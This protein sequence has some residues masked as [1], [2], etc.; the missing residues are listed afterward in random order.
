MIQM[1]EIPLN[2]ETLNILSELE[3][4]VKPEH[5]KCVPVQGR[6]FKGKKQ[7]YIN[8]DY[9]R[10]IRAKGR[11]H[12]GFPEASLSHSFDPAVLET[13]DQATRLSYLMKG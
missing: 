6:E 4:F 3:W 2:E 8:H 1:D 7:K 10:E 12:N 13:V 5:Y 9:F 11:G